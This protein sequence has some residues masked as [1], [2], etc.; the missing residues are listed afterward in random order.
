MT[1]KRAKEVLCIYF[2]LIVLVT[3]CGHKQTQ[4]IS[5]QPEGRKDTLTTLVKSDLKE[6]L[7]STL[8][9]DDEYA[10]Y[11]VVVADTGANY[12]TLRGKMLKI[13]KQFDIP[14]DTIGRYYNAKK[15][16][17]ALPDD[18]DDEIYAGDYFP[19][20]YP[21]G[22]LS[23]EYLSVYQPTAKDKTIALVTGIYENETSA[24]SALIAMKKVDSRSFKL[25]SK[26]YVGCM[27]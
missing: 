25:K 9:V 16:L 3:A 22:N 24:D 4:E 8:N 2:I 7:D 13:N 11:Y 20:R 18:A 5:E 1:Q 6:K 14:I 10:T 21:S 27:H 19:R 15:N 23:L 26:I 12:Y 17:I